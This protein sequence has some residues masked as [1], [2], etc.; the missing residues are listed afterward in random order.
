MCHLVD[1]WLVLLGAIYSQMITLWGWPLQLINHAGV[2][3]PGLTLDEERYIQHSSWTPRCKWKRL[4]FYNYIYIYI[5]IYKIPYYF[6]MLDLWSGCPVKVCSWQSRQAVESQPAESPSSKSPS[7][8][9]AAK[10][11]RTRGAPL[12][13]LLPKPPDWGKSL[14]IKWLFPQIYGSIP[15]KI[16]FLG[17][18]S[19]P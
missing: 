19:H 12:F 16:P 7:S 18:Y 5:Y 4:H 8:Q 10:A 1:P 6:L 11:E 13:A 9:A 15:M 14:G 3:D 17:G 2:V